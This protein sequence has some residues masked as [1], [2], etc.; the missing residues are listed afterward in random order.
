[1]AG[2][3]GGYRRNESLHHG[4]EAL[5]DVGGEGPDGEPERPDDLTEGEV[6]QSGD[7]ATGLGHRLDDDVCADKSSDCGDCTDDGAERELVHGIPFL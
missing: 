6:A 7:A 5:L 4:A 3:F 2:L 1:L